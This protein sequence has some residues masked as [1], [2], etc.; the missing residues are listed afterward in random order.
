MDTP[1][2]RLKYAR[3]KAGYPSA[4][5]AAEARGWNPST[6]RTHENGQRNYGLNDAKR[7]GPAFK[8]PWLWL[9]T[10]DQLAPPKKSAKS[11]L[12]SIPT[13]GEVAAGHWLDL[14]ITP[15]PEELE[16]Y[17][18]A[19]SGEYP[20]DAQYGLVVRGTSINKIAG[21]GEV[22][23]CVDMAIAGLEPVDGDIVIVERRRAQQGQH[24]VTAKRF[25]RLG[26]VTTLSPD[27]SDP[28]WLPIV[29]DAAE[30]TEEEV[31]VVARV[32][33]VYKPLK[34]IR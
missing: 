12:L 10:G 18:I 20:I 25:S 13:K 2:K 17:P 30:K 14:D 6:Y 32:I 28:R 22:L 9:L 26:K 33:G 5:K 15:D 27:S 4:T 31:E 21:P 34:N 23:H 19:P 29:F 1:A 11:A 7:Y 24:E 3:E 16:Q 8:V